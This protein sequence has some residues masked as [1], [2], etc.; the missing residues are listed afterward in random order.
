LKP[1][2]FLLLSELCE[3]SMNF[4]SCLL[5]QFTTCVAIWERHTGYVLVVCN[6]H[7]S[8]SVFGKHCWSDLNVGDRMVFLLWI[9]PRGEF[10]FLGP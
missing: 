6:V 10:S 4:V 2:D 9:G 8:Q 1:Q 5:S 7:Q 3:W